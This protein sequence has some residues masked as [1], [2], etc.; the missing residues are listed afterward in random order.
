MIECRAVQYIV[1]VDLHPGEFIAP[2]LHES[3]DII[4]ILIIRV[5]L[6]ISDSIE[7]RA[8]C[9]NGLCRHQHHDQQY[10]RAFR[11]EISPVKQQYRAVKSQ[12]C[13]AAVKEQVHV[14]DIFGH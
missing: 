5:A 8:H 13:D 14:V 4:V 9:R 6:R 1:A 2:A 3:C 11:N 7:C 12:P 10:H